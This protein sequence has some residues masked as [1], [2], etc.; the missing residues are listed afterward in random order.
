LAEREEAAAE[1]NDPD[2]LAK[3]VAA[4]AQNDPEKMDL[5]AD[6]GVDASNND[7]EIRGKIS[8]ARDNLDGRGESAESD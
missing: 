4:E 3:A 2:Y 5:D 7:G 1:V 6:G 8:D